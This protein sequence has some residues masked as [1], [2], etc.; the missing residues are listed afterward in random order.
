VCIAVTSRVSLLR[1]TAQTRWIEKIQERLQVTSSLLGDIKAVKMLGLT[2]VMSSLVQ[3]LR[4]DEINTSKSFRKL[5]VTTLLFCEFLINHSF[6]YVEPAAD[7]TPALAPIN[8]APVVTFMVYVVISIFWKSGTLLTAQAFTSIALIALLTDP[9][10]EFVQLLPMVIQS[11][12][13]FERIE[14]FYNLGIESKPNDEGAIS[15]VNHP[16]AEVELQSLAVINGKATK[17]PR[18]QAI[19]FLGGDFGWSENKVTLTD[20][21]VEIERGSVTVV[22]GPVGSGK[23]TFLSC[24][25]GDLVSIPTTTGKG[26]SR[27]ASLSETAY[28]SQEP[29]LEN[30]TIR[31]N[32]LGVSSFDVKWYD[33]VK[34]CC[35]LD[36][37]QLLKGDDTRVGSKGLSLS[38]G[39]KQRVVS[40]HPLSTYL[41]Y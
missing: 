4:V 40:E 22:V 35:G 7:M 38:G 34:S 14:E 11:L 37:D 3:K 39:Q 6:P 16:N 5:L 20:L 2:Q 28:C 33:T 26:P 9:L 24:L 32:I 21:N 29:W 36:G 31:Q 17:L 27:L 19:A 10:V 30:G 23:T 15:V 18:K 41:H 13:C 1:Q 25:L 8:L 12:A